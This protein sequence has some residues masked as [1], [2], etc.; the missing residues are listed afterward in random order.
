[1]EQEELKQKIL[2]VLTDTTLTDPTDKYIDFWLKCYPIGYE[3]AEK[4]WF[5][6][7]TAD[8]V[9]RIVYPKEIINSSYGEF[10]DWAE[11]DGIHYSFSVLKSVSLNNE[12]QK[13]VDVLTPLSELY[14]DAQGDPELRLRFKRIRINFYEALCSKRFGLYNIPLYNEVAT[15][16]IE[17][18]NRVERIV[19]EH[20]RQVMMRSYDSVGFEARN[21]EDAEKVL[22]DVNND[23][24]YKVRIK[25]YP[26]FVHFIN[27]LVYLGE[28]GKIIT[29]M[30]NYNTKYPQ[31]E[32]IKKEIA[33]L[34]L[35]KR[36]K[37][38]YD[39]AMAT[40]LVP[41]D[42]LHPNQDPARFTDWYSKTLRDNFESIRNVI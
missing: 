37:E 22:I 4:Q 12:V 34:L 29:K 15:K 11:F 30:L 33:T 26:R 7:K 39:K 17:N 38:A 36:Y 20:E 23:V 2:A 16:M 41:L 13:V 32:G 28:D 9:D 8:Q 40:P 5:T 42:P 24:K 18:I 14:E 10:N 31:M 19:K 27:W 25:F 3:K 1:M 35:G 21:K 6:P